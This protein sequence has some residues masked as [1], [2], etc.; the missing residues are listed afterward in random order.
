MVLKFA[1]QVRK[2]RMF[3]EALK[4]FPGAELNDDSLKAA[5]MRRT[6]LI[7]AVFSAAVLLVTAGGFG[8]A[9]R[10][11]VRLPKVF[12]SHMVLQQEKP[13][14]IWGWAQPNETI[15][16][17]IATET[18]KAQA[19]ERGE[20]KAVLPAMKAGGPYTL[21]VS[22]SSTVRFDDVMVGEVWLCSGQSNMEMGIGAA[23]DA[24][25]EI[26]AADYPGIRLLKVP[27][28][29]TPEPQDDMEGAWKVCSPKTVAEGGWGGFTA[30]GYYF[31]RELHK[32]LGVTVG[33]IDATWGGTRIEPW[34]PP[35]GFAAVP[36]L[37]QEYEQLQLGD[38]HAPAHQQRLEQI[39][40]DVERW[41]AA[42]RQALVARTNVPTMP[43]YPG[44]LLP[45]HEL[46]HR[47]ALYN[48]MI[49]PLQPF[50]LRGAIWYQGE[51]NS[52]E[53]MLYA[54]RMKALIG[55]WRQAWGEGDFPF[56]FVQIA[57]FTY[58][59]KPEVIG[60]FWEAQAAAQAVP[61]SGM[62][63]INDV[64]NLKDIHPGNKQEVGR[65][66]ALWALANT[67]AQQNLVYSGPTFKAMSVEGDKLRLTF[68]HVG[69]GL[70]SRDGKPLNW[71]EVIDA[72]EGGF[73]KAEVQI[74]RSALLLS[75]PGVKHPVA[76][77]FAW[78]ML[79]EPNFMNTEGL[80]AS[81]FRAGTV[82]KRDLLALN[83]P[84]AKDYQLVYDLDLAKLGQT[85]TYDA[86]HRA[87]LHQPF[88]RI[89]YFL[90]LQGSDSKTE[91]VYVSMDA[92][93]ESLEKL[94]VPTVR[95]G[96]HFQRNISNMNVF[97]N[98]KGIITGAG[99]AGGNLEFWPN[100]Y[101]PANSAKVPNA[102]AQA[103]D[104]G[105]EPSDP[106]NGYGSMQV[107]NHDAKQTLF[108][109]NH[110]LEGSRADVGIGNQPTGSPD[111][112]FAA[113]AGSYQAKRLRVLVRC[114]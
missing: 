42:A 100:N 91:Y 26:A 6:K 19:N 64:G 107:H 51:S 47:T 61:N 15:T 106:V 93:T 71:F 35:E 40:N 89:A 48:A 22:A 110:W 1:A 57:P 95:S 75:A 45:P 87:R 49:H 18:R 59:H 99:L 101:G 29:W 23:R 109:L 13:V 86:D 81:A 88:D 4:A 46:Q 24:Q 50:A 5:N 104:F 72:D 17:Q 8:Q 76:M 102:S 80:P 112:T 66:L 113:N 37:K 63:V 34:T 105:D 36:A 77:R 82:P 97:S 43:T 74:D 7:P 39:L 53:G 33:L 27:K 58:G 79:A 111:W 12:G 31:G 92:F 54:E 94:G 65:R 14:V 44:E 25:Q 32:K 69:G 70:A 114:K 55:G 98:A 16:L 62:V 103:Y 56:Y 96:A 84:E 38:P 3:C 28:R 68:D 67:Y 73:V 85:I 9:A 10:A 83:V 78:S 2:A 11:E 90:E 30:A 60:E 108:A 52:G 21:T 41:L 20:W